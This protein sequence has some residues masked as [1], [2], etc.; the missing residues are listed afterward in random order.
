MAA[1]GGQGC[2]LRVRQGRPGP[3]LVGANGAGKTT[4]LKAVTPAAGGG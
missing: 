2:E 4:T 1:S 3:S